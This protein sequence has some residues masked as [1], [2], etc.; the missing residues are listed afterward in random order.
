MIR[1]PAQVRATTYETVASDLAQQKEK[2]QINA[3]ASGEINYSNNC[4]CS[5][6]R[7]TQTAPMTDSPMS[8]DSTTTATPIVTTTT[9][10][11]VINTH[12]HPRIILIK[13]PTS[14]SSSSSSS[15]N[16][17]SNRA[18]QTAPRTRL[19]RIPFL[20]GPVSTPSPVK[21][22][23]PQ[24]SS[25]VNSTIP[26]TAY[27][28]GTAS[29]TPGMTIYPK[30]QS[31]TMSHPVAIDQTFGPPT[32]TEMVTETETVQVSSMPQTL[33]SM[34]GIQLTG[35]DEQSSHQDVSGAMPTA[36]VEEID[37][38]V[39]IDEYLQDIEATSSTSSS[40]GS[41]KGKEIF[42]ETDILDF[43]FDINLIT[44]DHIE[45]KKMDQCNLDMESSDNINNDYLTTPIEDL[46]E[47][48]SLGEDEI[49]D[50]GAMRGIDFH[51]QPSSLDLDI[52]NI[53]INS[54]NPMLCSSQS[55]SSIIPSYSQTKYF[56]EQP[57]LADENS[58]EDGGV[59]LCSQESLGYSHLGVDFGSN[60][61]PEQ[62]ENIADILQN[63]LSSVGGSTAFKRSVT[64]EPET[65]PQK[66]SKLILNLTTTSPLLESS[67]VIGTP[68]IINDVLSFETNVESDD[69]PI[70]PNASTH[71]K[72]IEDLRSVEEE[73]TNDFSAPNTPYSASSSCTA[74]PTCQ[75][76]F[77]G[78]LT[79]PAS[80]AV[81][82]A[83]TSQF[84]TTDT[85]ITGNKRKRGRPAKEHADG[86]DPDLMSRMTDD[87]VK[88]YKDRIKNNEASRISRRKTR[89]REML[90]KQEEDTLVS[91]NNRL[92]AK[93]RRSEEK[94]LQ[95]KDYLMNRHHHNST[96]VKQERD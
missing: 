32:A 12:P 16:N 17:K 36:T 9:I 79:A 62:N 48:S 47:L 33:A 38:P 53:M 71:D 87:E 90:E 31:S 45:Q 85:S 29:S 52:D 35:A 64:L 49:C 84:T 94:T 15:S 5:Q 70:T 65:Q 88:A 66:R 76:G 63:I 25:S 10:P 3:K 74:A 23:T 1:E 18:E 43:D 41:D 30:Q 28:L 50:M 57:L 37:V 21:R 14:S 83:S 86:P 26:A 67:D 77:A 72:I 40:S 54:Q 7:I 78:F 56:T 19:I 93:L 24:T 6:R 51:Q 68:Q 55:Q 44:E 42:T 75:T 73:T 2:K 4:T 92:Q 34:A 95:F 11:I 60:I 91:E 81:S 80:P 82:I 39:F 89:T 27:R 46:A 69:R 59:Y 96:F 58:N 8:E 22:T 20:P 13:V 61:E